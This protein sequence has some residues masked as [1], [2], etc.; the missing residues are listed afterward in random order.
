MRD[1]RVQLFRQIQ[2]MSLRFF[3]QTKTGDIISRVSTDVNGVQE[4]V[5]RIFVTLA[6]NLII[7]MT[8]IAVM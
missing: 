6:F 2:K 5:T 4:V 3:T 7:I 8:T 1:L